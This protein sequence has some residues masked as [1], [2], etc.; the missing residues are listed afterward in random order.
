MKA[1][2]KTLLCIHVCVQKQYANISL[3]LKAITA[4]QDDE[5]PGMASVEQPR[6]EPGKQDQFATTGPDKVKAGI[7]GVTYGNYL[8]CH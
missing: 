5:I 1:L 8:S 4:F 3:R 6:G 2:L 7:W